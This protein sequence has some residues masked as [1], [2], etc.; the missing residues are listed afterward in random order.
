M[1]T[2]LLTTGI[3]ILAFVLAVQ[4][5]YAGGVT[6][7][8]WYGG[9]EIYYID[10][11]LEK[12]TTER[13]SNQIYLIGGNRLYQANVVLHI[14]GEPGFTPHWN[15]NV[16]HT[17]PGVTVQDIINAGL[18]SSHF[19][20]EGVVFDDAADVMEAE[21]QGLTEEKLMEELEEDKRE[22]YKEMYGKDPA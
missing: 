3:T 15:V 1:K 5:A 22:V 6:N 16:V 7:N 18:S 4:F 20:S 8:G 19:T 11:G 10:Q 2:R 13:A 17:A 21:R 12:N 9:R 14:P